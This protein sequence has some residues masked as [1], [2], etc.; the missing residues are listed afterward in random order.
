M[1]AVEAIKTIVSVEQDAKQMLEDARKRSV[2]LRRKAERQIQTMR[3]T[4]MDSA[5]KEAEKIRT[6]AEREALS[7]ASTYLENSERDIAK[8][9][10]EARRRI[11]QA[12]DAVVRLIFGEKT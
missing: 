6:S 3:E 9:T 8:E 2:E 12:V 10:D 4:M 5:K 11:P 7:K 1:S